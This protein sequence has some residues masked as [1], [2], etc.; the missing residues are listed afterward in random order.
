MDLHISVNEEKKVSF[1]PQQVIDISSMGGERER[2]RERERDANLAFYIFPPNLQ[3]PLTSLLASGSSSQ[4]LI[5]LIPPPAY[6]DSKSVATDTGGLVPMPP[7]DE[8]ERP[9]RALNEREQKLISNGNPS[10]PAPGFG[11]RQAGKIAL[12]EPQVRQWR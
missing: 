10:N 6:S 8:G 7:A 11:A 3:S 5:D 2:E 4:L 12:L 1:P 9:Q